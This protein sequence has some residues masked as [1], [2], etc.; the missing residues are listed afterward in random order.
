[1]DPKLGGAETI[2]TEGNDLGTAPT[3]SPPTPSAID[4]EPRTVSGSLSRYRLDARLGNGGMGEVVS[5]HDEQIGRPVA[6]KRMRS[7]TPSAKRSARF[8]ARLGSRAG[9]N[10]PQSCRST[11]SGTIEHG[12]PFFVMK[13]LTG[14][15]MADATRAKARRARVARSSLLRAFVDVCLAIE[16]AHTRGV[17]HRDLKPVKHHARRLRRGLRARLGHRARGRRYADARPSSRDVDS[18]EAGGRVSAPCSARRGTWRLSSCAVK[19]TRRPR[20]CLRARLH[21]VR[22]ARAQAPPS[23]W[24]RGAA[25]DARQR[26]R[27]PI[28]ARSRRAAGARRDLRR[29]DPARPRR[30]L[31]HGPR[32]RQRCP[33]LPRRRSRRRATQ[34][35]RTGRSRDRSHRT[36]GWRW[37][38]RARD[39]NAR[40]RSR[41]RP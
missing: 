2:A 26:R 29:G 6:I 41:A 25:H 15:T 31:Q 17:V 28:A 38:A 12:R 16:F 3:V 36:R 1:M 23:A 39:R 11:S 9:S 34:A 37:P 7:N 33:A 35:A 40:C 20:R 24:A 10:I 27:A 22:D 30:P 5:A 13:Q 32:A 21:A 18:L 4:G 19:A 8:C 14:T